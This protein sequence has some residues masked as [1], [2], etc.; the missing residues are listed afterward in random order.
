LNFL[1]A[2]P[3]H[4]FRRSKTSCTF[5]LRALLKNLKFDIRMFGHARM[6]S[7][8][9]PK[10]QRR[11]R[12]MSH[13]VLAQLN[14]LRDHVRARIEATTDYKALMSVEKAIG[15]INALLPV[16]AEAAV[17]PVEAA[18]A[19]E[20]IAD[21]ATVATE[22]VA[23][24]EAEAPAEAVAA[25]EAPAETAT[26]AAVEE[27]AVEEAPAEAAAEVAVEAAA[28]VTVPEIP[29]E[30]RPLVAELVAAAAELPAAA[31]NTNQ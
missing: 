21:A 7:E 18:A 24:A 6:S 22:A 4:P 30:D 15:E 3:L 16:A 27:V 8:T 13:D 28:E 5:L 14:G 23:E 19:E 29:A 2:E 17:A 25:E 26:E 11:G 20:A 31:A 1:C 9:L 10:F 12:R